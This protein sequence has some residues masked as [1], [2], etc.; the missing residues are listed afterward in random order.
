MCV[1]LIM[2]CVGVVPLD[3]QRYTVGGMESIERSSA[4]DFSRIDSIGDSLA[5]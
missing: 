2:A 4:V 1:P 5:N 3:I